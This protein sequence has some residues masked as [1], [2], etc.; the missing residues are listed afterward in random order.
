MFLNEI[1]RHAIDYP[2]SLAVVDNG[3]EVTYREFARSIDAVR[4]ILMQ[5]QLPPD[6]IIVS[7]SSNL[8]FDWVL[9]LALRSLGHTTVSAAAYETIENLRMR[10]VGA[11]VCSVGHTKAIDD[12]ARARPECPIVTVPRQPTTNLQEGVSPELIEGGRFGDHILYSSGTTGTDKKLRYSGPLLERCV[13]DPLTGP[14]ARLI[15]RDDVYHATHL[16]PSCKGG[17]IHPLVCWY[18]GAT[19]IFDQRTNWVEHFFDYPVTMTTLVPPKLAQLC[20]SGVSRPRDHPKFRLLAG[21]DFINAELAMTAVRK[22]GCEVLVVYGSTEI[23][24][25]LESVVRT[26]EDVVWLTPN[27]APDVEV[28]DEHDHP[29]PTGEEGILRIRFSPTFPTEYMDDPE[30]TAQHFRN[31]YF[32]PGD[33]AVGRDDGRIRILGRVADVL[34]LGGTKRAVG[35]FEDWARNLLKVDDLCMFVQQT[36]DG[37]EMLIVAIEGSQL[38]DRAR[39]EAVAKRFRQVPLVLFPLI[40]KFPRSENEMMKVNRREVLRLVRETRA[41]QELPIVA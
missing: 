10:D 5:S 19:V 9:L 26:E 13:A 4:S 39:L 31:G 40:N 12:F 23:R 27:F 32:Y 16:G 41:Q 35:P 22:F 3:N 21:G 30:S 34:N 29:V 28:V 8:Y 1:Y 37:K 38:P 24:I 17:Y 2:E 33:M 11:L 6:R 20:K 7:M 18:R 36:N 14:S 15:S 25:A